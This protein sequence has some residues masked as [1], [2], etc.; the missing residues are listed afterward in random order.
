MGEGLSVGG[1]GCV[2][3]ERVMEGHGDSFNRTTIKKVKKESHLYMVTFTHSH[4]ADL[5]ITSFSLKSHSSFQH[6]FVSQVWQ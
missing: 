3:R 6:Q 1:S 2:G 4:L 5:Q